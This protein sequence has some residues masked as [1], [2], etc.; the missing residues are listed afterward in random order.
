[1]KKIVSIAGLLALWLPTVSR[2][3]LYAPN[4]AGVAMGQWYT[5]VKDVDATKKFWALYGGKPI[6]IDGMEVIKFPGLLIF[7]APGMPTG[8]SVGTAVNHVG[9]GVP[10]TAKAL[11]SWKAL[12]GKT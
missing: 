3:Q 6:K 4:A 7:L 11:G 12:G 2:A 10:D 9:F 8:P 1:M 5:I